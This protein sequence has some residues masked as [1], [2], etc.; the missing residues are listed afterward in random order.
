MKVMKASN[1]G[2]LLLLV[3]LLMEQAVGV[4]A[5]LFGWAFDWISELLGV[6]CMIPLLGDAICEPCDSDGCSA[7]GVCERRFLASP[8]CVCNVGWSGTSCL[9]RLGGNLLQGVSL[10]TILSVGN[11]DTY[12]SCDALKGDLTTAALY[13][14]DAMIERMVRIKFAND[15][16][17]GGLGSPIFVSGPGIPGGPILASPVDEADGSGGNAADIPTTETSFETN[18]QIKGVDEADK[19]KSNGVKAFAVYGREI[20]EFVVAT[21]SVQSRTVLPEIET[22]DDNDWCGRGGE[23][24]GML[25]IEKSLIVFAREYAYYCYYGPFPEAA[26]MPP[27]SQPIVQSDGA[28]K[29][30]RRVNAFLVKTSLLT[31]T[32]S[33]FSSGVPLRY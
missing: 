14:S 9:A 23:I 29:V 7:N 1:N 20:V 24:V 33:K 5:Q 17:Y 18:N 6:F 16:S 22:P 15:W 28:T 11:S 21:N 13:T 32:F 8:R 31:K 25:L 2:A 10:P 30:S 3:V 19:L 12:A 27:D 26:S 4:R